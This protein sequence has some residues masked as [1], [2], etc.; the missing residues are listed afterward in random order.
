MA[1]GVPVK[2]M[3]SHPTKG[4]G[5]VLDR[6]S[7][8]AFTCEFKYDGERGQVHLLDDGSVQVFSRNSENN[9]GKFPDVVKLI[10]MVRTPLCIPFIA[11]L[12]PSLV[13]LVLWCS[14]EHS[15]L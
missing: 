6:F 2:P 12:P 10:P 15:G 9:T 7:G 5:E 13:V 4:I 14:G 8:C 3:L 1:E 11:I